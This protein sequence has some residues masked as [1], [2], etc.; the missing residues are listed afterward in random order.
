MQERARSQE[1]A[2]PFAEA[3]ARGLFIHSASFEALAARLSSW[4]DEAPA[5]LLISGPDASGKKSMIASWLRGQDSQNMTLGMVRGGDTNPGK[6]AEDLLFAFGHRPADG[7]DALGGLTDF[8]EDC[9]RDGQPLLVVVS[10]LHQAREGV[11]QELGEVL[12]VLALGGHGLHLLA[13]ADPEGWPDAGDPL[14]LEAM[15]RIAVFPMSPEE[16]RQALTAV[17]SEDDEGLRFSE[18]A[19][20][21]LHE[22]S[23]GLM[24]RLAECADAAAKYA[25]AFGRNKVERNDVEVTCEVDASPSPNDIAKAL[26]VLSRETSEADDVAPNDETP[27]ASSDDQR[28]TSLSHI[29]VVDDPELTV[30]EQFYRDLIKIRGET[31]ALVQDLKNVRQATE[32]LRERQGKKLGCL[33]RG[34]QNLRSLQSGV[35]S[36]ERFP[37]A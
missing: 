6:V 36:G 27:Q 25:Q 16:T 12:D 32:F 15:E 5:P 33:K 2:A 34:T 19:A 4:W 17:T 23:Y 9:D 31:L 30:D 3:R 13:T 37:E 21:L 26:E 1:G 8:A 24:G 22:H 29:P 14:F 11:L 10:D 20:D 7:A 28:A 18:E 35:T